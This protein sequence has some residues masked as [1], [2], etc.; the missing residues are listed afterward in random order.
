M[1][2]E[3]WVRVHKHF[4][5]KNQN[6]ELLYILLTCSDWPV[7][8][9][10]WS[11]LAVRIWNVGVK[12][13]H[14]FKVTFVFMVISLAFINSC[15][16]S[17]RIVQAAFFPSHFLLSWNWSSLAQWLEQTA[18]VSASNWLSRKRN[19]TKLIKWNN[20]IGTIF[21]LLSLAVQINV[22]S[23]ISMGYALWNHNVLI[24]TRTSRFNSEIRVWAH[25]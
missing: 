21:L 15:L 3:F 5:N 6:T 20:V 25:F 11:F 22:W 10:Q 12:F 16:M 7:L 14:P 18:H 23:W 8:Q 2:E 19:K 9:W 13:T 1:N 4:R 17:N 24:I